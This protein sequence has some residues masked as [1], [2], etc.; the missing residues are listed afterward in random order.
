MPCSIGRYLDVSEEHVTTFG[1]EYGSRMSSKMSEV[2]YS[3]GSWKKFK[4]L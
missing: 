4:L 1:I 3:M 2:L